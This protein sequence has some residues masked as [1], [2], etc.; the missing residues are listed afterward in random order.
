[1]RDGGSLTVMPT[2]GL[3]VHAGGFIGANETNLTL[4]NMQSGAGYIRISPYFTGTMPKIKVLYQTKSTLDSGA[5]KDATW[6]YIGAPGEDCQ[7]T[8]DHI[9]WLYHWSEAQGW[10]NK[11][12]TLTLEPFAGY[13][14][15]QYGKPTCELVAQPINTNQTITLT[16]TSAFSY[17]RDHWHLVISLILTFLFCKTGL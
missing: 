10:I 17:S 1:M 11:T 5:N 15:T 12:G 3:T 2:G 6:Q 9:T 16:K 8:V 7:F 14:I 4:H 13:A